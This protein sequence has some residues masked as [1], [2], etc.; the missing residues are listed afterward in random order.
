MLCSGTSH[1]I[2][3]L[4]HSNNAIFCSP[5]PS[6]DQFDKISSTEMTI[7]R[8]FPFWSRLPMWPHV[9]NNIKFLGRWGRIL[10]VTW[11]SNE[12]SLM[13]DLFALNGIFFS[14]KD[15]LDESFSIFLGRFSPKIYLILTLRN[16]HFLFAFP[17]YKTVPNLFFLL[18]PLH[19]WSP[20]QLLSFC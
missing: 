1:K 16:C 2:Q 8:P 4:W 7:S 14:F 11:I 13:L 5:T 9:I 15:I 3:M 19:P 10:K 6:F 12:W 18:F 17:T 20:L